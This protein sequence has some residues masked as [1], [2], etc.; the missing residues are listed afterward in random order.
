MQWTSNF[1]WFIA[2]PIIHSIYANWRISDLK[3]ELVLFFDFIDAVH[4]IR[5]LSCS[6]Q[7]KGNY[8]LKI[9]SNLDVSAIEVL[10]CIWRESIHLEYPKSASRT[11]ADSSC[12][13]KSKLLMTGN[14]LSVKVTGNLRV[15]YFISQA[16]RCQGVDRGKKYILKPWAFDLWTHIRNTL[17]LIFAWSI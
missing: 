16:L 8:F 15:F 10:S 14:Y 5:E 17:S 4:K 6:F 11:S 7:E 1:S 9:P 3:F 2:R 13:T 12:C